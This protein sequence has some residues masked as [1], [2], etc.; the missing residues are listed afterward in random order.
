M[1]NIQNLGGFV[2]ISSPFSKTGSNIPGTDTGSS[3]AILKYDYCIP[4]A[5]ENTVKQRK[6]SITTGNALLMKKSSNAA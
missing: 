1:K 5:E 2:L 4:P 3:S 6:K